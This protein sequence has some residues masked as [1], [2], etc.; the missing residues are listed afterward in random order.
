MR[1]ENQNA[2]SAGSVNMDWRDWRPAGYLNRSGQ[3]CAA[4]TQ[5]E[6]DT[7]R[8]HSGVSSWSSNKAA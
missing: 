1:V 7:G 5:V 2:M 8:A 4:G 6:K 3:P